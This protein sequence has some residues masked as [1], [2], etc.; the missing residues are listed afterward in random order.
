VSSAVPLLSLVERRLVAAL[1][2]WVSAFSNYS[3]WWGRIP[4]V[5]D[6]YH[7]A[8]RILK[9]RGRSERIAP[10]AMTAPKKA[11]PLCPQKFPH[12]F[13]FLRATSAFPHVRTR[14]ALEPSHF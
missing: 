14:R 11:P 10:T 12:P 1:P 8:G 6:R 9:D 4:I 3:F 13:L 5:T 7:V 2:R